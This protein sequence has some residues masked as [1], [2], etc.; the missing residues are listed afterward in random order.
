MMKE[1][2]CFPSMIGMQLTQATAYDPSDLPD[3]IDKLGSEPL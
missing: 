2:L 1:D 3:W